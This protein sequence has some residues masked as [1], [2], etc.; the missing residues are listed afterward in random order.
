MRETYIG[1][2]LRV[3]TMPIETTKNIKVC[4]NEHDISMI[5]TSD[6]Y[7]PQCGEELED[8]TTL[9][10]KWPTLENFFWPGYEGMSQLFRPYEKQIDD[11]MIVIANDTYSGDARGHNPEDINCEMIERSIAELE[12]TYSEQIRLLRETAVLVDVKFG[13]IERAY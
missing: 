8:G 10:R 1:A 12:S 3:T 7:C 9:I 13:V 2:Y 4:P 11:E 6:R 5:R